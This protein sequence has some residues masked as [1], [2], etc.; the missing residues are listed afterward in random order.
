MSDALPARPDLAQLRTRAKEL[1]NA[2]RQGD[3]TALARFTSQLSARPATISLASA[4]L[5]I[6]REL[7]FASWPR[8]KAA[9]DAGRSVPEFLAASIDGRPHQAGDLLRADPAIAGRDLRAATVLGEAAIVRA[10]IAAD[11]EVAV[12]LDDERGWPPLLYACYSHWHR[13]DPGRAQGLADVV[14][15]LLDAGASPHTNDGG[16][17]RFRSALRGA[18]EVGNPGVAEVLLDAGAHPDPGQPI[19][20]AAGQRDHR[21]LKLLLAHGARVAGTWAI[22]AAIDADDAV[23]VSL[24]LAALD[25]DAARDNA[26]Q[27]LPEAVSRAGM[28]VVSTLIE[29]GADPNATDDDGQSALRLAVRAGRPGVA[30]RLRAAGAIDDTTDL[31]H[32]I[33]A[34]LGGDR[35]SAIRLRV[36]LS[37]QDKAILVDAP[38]RHSAD[39][40]A[41]MLDVGFPHNAR[42]ELGEQPLHTAAYFGNAPVVRVLLEAGAEVD[43]R[44]TRFDATPLAFAT[45]GSGEQAGKPGDWRETVRLLIEAGASRRDVWVTGKPPSEELV[46][47]LHEYG[48]GPE[49]EPEAAPDDDDPPG[50]LGTGTLAEVAR[51]LKAAYDERDLDLLASLLHPDVHWTGSCT[52]S[53]Q[54]IDWYRR[55]HAEGILSTVHGLETDRDAVIMD[56]DV[57][58]QAEGARPSPQHV[59]QVFTVQDAQ[60]TDIRGYPDRRSALARDD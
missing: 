17:Q 35:A 25:Q 45:V 47:L 43:A 34:A 56:L 48:I 36:E 50:E 18:I 39:T 26:T 13:I 42:N 11:P 46:P 37:E 51:H 49:T 31:D 60:I 33:G 6:A 12:A 9:I 53:T 30:D 19:G 38:E 14:Q 22:S 16:R 23:A 15:A 2:A 5:V 4:Q 3:E 27:A 44:D 55:L 28:E 29:A 58:G 20:E 41:L 59:Y 8:L 1:R 24:L 52:N 32:F 7:G 54:V 10:A 40:I 57:V 21:N